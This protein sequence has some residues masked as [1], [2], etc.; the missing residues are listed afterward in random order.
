MGDGIT[1]NEIVYVALGFHEVGFMD[2]TGKLVRNQHGPA[3]VIGKF[4]SITTR[5]IRGR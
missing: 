1:A 2:E 5:S 3:A 4:L